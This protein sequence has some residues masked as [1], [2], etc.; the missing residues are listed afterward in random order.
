[1]AKENLYKKEGEYTPDNLIAGLN[2][3]CLITGVKLKEGQGV[4]KRGTVIGI[5]KTGEAVAV[6]KSK[7]DGSN[8]PYGILTDDVDTTESIG[9]TVYIS[10]LFNKKALHFGGKDDK[11]SDYENKLR[12]LGVFLK[13][14]I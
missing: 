3:P 10:G 2:V 7:D 4:L 11:A 9:A 13:N 14:V 5:L 1:M 8:I 6:D 12:E